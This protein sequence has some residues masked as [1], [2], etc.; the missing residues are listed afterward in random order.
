MGNERI[1]ETLRRA[2]KFNA[3]ITRQNNYEQNKLE[4]E[5]LEMSG[6]VLSMLNRAKELGQNQLA[7]QAEEIVK[8]A[9]EQNL[10]YTLS[11]SLGEL[12]LAVLALAQRDASNLASETSSSHIAR[13]CSWSNSGPSSSL[14]C[15]C[16]RSASQKEGRA[17]PELWREF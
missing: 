11:S 9:K 10:A 2:M 16:S 3:L 5:I 14:G 1:D 8:V 12:P 17:K 4:P 6:A 7:K 15:S 13:P